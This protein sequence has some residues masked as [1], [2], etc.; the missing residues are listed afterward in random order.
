MT[1]KELPP[2]LYFK[3]D[4][5][6]ESLYGMYDCTSFTLGEIE[7]GLLVNAFITFLSTNRLLLILILSL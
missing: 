3:S 6:F 2:K 7:V 4:V 5:S 1:V